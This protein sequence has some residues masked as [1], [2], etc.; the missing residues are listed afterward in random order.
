LPPIFTSR[1]KD[2]A[3]GI[4]NDGTVFLHPLPPVSGTPQQYSGGSTSVHVQPQLPIHYRLI[5]DGVHGSGAAGEITHT[6]ISSNVNVHINGLHGSGIAGEI[7]H[8]S[9]SSNV[10]INGVHGSGIAGD[11]SVNIISGGD[12]CAIPI[13]ITSPTLLNTSDALI[14]LTDGFDTAVFSVWLNI[15]DDGGIHGLIFTNQGR[16]IT[17]QIQNDDEGSP[18]IRIIAWD[19]SNVEIVSANYNFTNWQ[20]W[21]NILA[22]IDTT[23]QTIQVY[24]NTIIGGILVETELTPSSITWAS[25]NP[26]GNSSG[27]TWNV[28]VL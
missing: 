14:G 10:H 2:K 7:T 18:E 24:A 3:K 20:A 19:T 6:S 22:S 25:S 12:Y 13:K 21:V 17:I 16:N 23:S 11:V 8:T 26:I 27:V 5:I 4:P 9:I 28:G 15:P 1:I